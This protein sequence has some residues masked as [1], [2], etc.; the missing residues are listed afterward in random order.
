MAY[1]QIVANHYDKAG[2]TRRSLD[3]LR[4]MVDLDPDNV[5]S[6][7]KLADLYVREQHERRG[8]GR[9]RRRPP[10][11]SSA[12]TAPTTT[13]AWPSGVA[14][15]RAE[16]PAA[17][18]RAGRALPAA[19]RSEA[20]AGQA[21]G[22]L[23]GRPARHRHAARCWRW[24]SRGWGRPRRRCRSTRSWPRSTRSAGS[25]H[26]AEQIW[27]QVAELDPNDP[28]VLAAPAG[29]AAPAAAGADGAPRAAPPRGRPAQPHRR[30]RPRRPYQ[31]APRAAPVRAPEAEG[32][33]AIGKLL[34][35]TDVYVKYG[36][37]DKALE[38]LRKVFS[39]DPENIDAHEKA[40]HIYVGRRTTTRR[41]P[42]SCSTCC[43]CTRARGD[44]A[45]GAAV[46]ADDARSRTPRT[47]RCR[48]SSRR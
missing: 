20:R 25:S 47:P 34:T 5:A 14:A 39:V 33:A 22:L 40:Y 26:D 18:A 35:E 30:G 44:A 29:R 24:P 15:L 36:L 32:R 11:T 3:V 28:D 9:V 8:G 1:Y 41:P 38:H 48:S 10:S 17:G 13:C 7:I 43:G 46:P 27:E 23:Q 42:S 4:K 6:R 16:Q 37:H 21:A 45:A 12:T 2:D 19:R 31:P